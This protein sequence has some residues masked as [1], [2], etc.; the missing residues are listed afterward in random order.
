[1]LRVKEECVARATRDVELTG[2]GVSTG[3]RGS[4]GVVVVVAVVVVVVLVVAVV[5]VVVGVGVG[6]GG[7][8]RSSSG[9]VVKKAH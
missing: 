5:V 6:V 2:A 8:I 9:T 3:G 1:M 4:S 7:T